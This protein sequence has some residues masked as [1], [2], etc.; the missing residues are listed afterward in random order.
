[1]R[2]LIP[3]LCLVT[4]LVAAHAASPSENSWPQWRGPL[5]TGVAP[6]GKVPSEWSEEKNVQWKYQIHGFG[7]STPI[8]W[9]NQVFIQTA[10]PTGKKEEKPQAEEPSGR[11][12]RGEVPTEYQDFVILSVDRTTGK[13]LWQKTARTELPHEGHHKDHGFAS[14]SPVTDGEHLYVYFGSR[15]LYCYDLSGNLKWEKDLG[16]MRTRN[17]FGEG[18]SPALHG[19][20]L[21]VN[22]D[23]EG[24]DFIAALD[25]RTGKE[26]WRKP[27]EEATTWVTPVIF[28][29][30]GKTQ[31]VVSATTKIRS[32]DL[33]NGEVIWECSGMTA[34]VIPTP[35]I[36]FDMVYALSG[37]RGN[38]LLAIKLGRTGDLTG[39]DA[40]AWSH[41]KNTPYVPSPLLYGERLYFFGGNNAIL[42]CFNAKTGKVLID[43][44]RL[45]GIFGVYGS[46]IAADGKVFLVGREGVSLVIKDSDKLELLATNKLDDKFDASPA[47]SG[48]Q[49]FLRGHKFLYA[50][51]DTKEMADK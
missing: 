39:T 21:V 33:N 42:S 15:G 26:I 4:A 14:A 10:V 16:D 47:I 22:W 17:G 6:K 45:P 48:N 9:G 46:P 25:K 50:I 41:N 7:S 37:F 8:V 35:V 43:A 24:E 13:Q 5:A 2:I 3:A 40:I 1:M 28:E 51:S 36:G 11:R 12:G 34:N 49:L 18:S 29:H 44:E 23:H 20:T 27:R 32:Y 38:S 31:V 30:S 19:N